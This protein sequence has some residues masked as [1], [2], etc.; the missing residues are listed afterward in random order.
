MALEDELIPIC[1]RFLGK[2][3]QDSSPAK[4]P[5]IFSKYVNSSLKVQITSE[6]RSYIPFLASHR[7][8]V[9]CALLEAG[10][11]NISLMHSLP[12]L[13]YPVIPKT[14]G[15]SQTGLLGIV[16]AVFRTATALQSE[17]CNA[18][19]SA[20][21]ASAERNARSGDSGPLCCG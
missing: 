11:D 8:D 3:Q 4:I 7:N 1:H 18:C 19:A 16:R 14:A 10:T 15:G 17:Y 2:S 12:D 9:R 21:V 13:N 20:A 6:V 5:H